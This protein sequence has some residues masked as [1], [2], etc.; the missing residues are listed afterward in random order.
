MSADITHQPILTREDQADGKQLAQGCSALDSDDL[1]ALFD[2]LRSGK[3]P[4]LE[5]NVLLATESL[6]RA[7]GLL[8][9]QRGSLLVP[10]C[11]ALASIPQLPADVLF[12]RIR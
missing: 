1:Q 11:P 4:A 12:A 2:A 10:P 7:P 5:R 8:P 6:L 9:V 3:A